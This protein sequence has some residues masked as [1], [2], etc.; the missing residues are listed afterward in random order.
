MNKVN[1]LLE[2]Y[3]SLNVEVKA[4]LW[5]TVCSFMQKGISFITVPIFTRLM[6][7]KQYGQFT[8]T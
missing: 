5:F 1:A 7:L 4:I 6:T 3:H 8:Y 2:K